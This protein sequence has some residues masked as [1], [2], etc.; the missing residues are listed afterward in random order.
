[1]KLKNIAKEDNK[2]VNLQL[3]K[4]SLFVKPNEEF[5]VE[6]KYA[7]EL[8]ETTIN[9]KPIVEKVTTKVKVE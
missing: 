4:A 5:E 8:L 1:M 9:D 7:K 3:K 2:P 6:D